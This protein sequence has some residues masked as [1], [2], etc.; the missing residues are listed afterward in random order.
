MVDKQLSDR[1]ITL[2]MGF[3][4]FSEIWYPDAILGWKVPT[5]M[6]GHT[7]SAGNPKYQDTKDRIFTKE[8]ARI[9]LINDLFQ[10]GQAIKNR[11]K[12]H[13]N[14]NQYGALISLVYNIGETDFAGSTL[15]KKLNLGDYQGASDEFEK[16]HKSGGRIVEGLCNRR[17]VEYQMFIEV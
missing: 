14:A 4:S 13:L 11:V 10:Y 9:T 2:I 16:W 6:Y 17:E 5:V 12:V 7:D 15:L 8:E 1:A 3:E